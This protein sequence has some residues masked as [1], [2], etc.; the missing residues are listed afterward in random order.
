M[1]TIFSAALGVT[2]AAVI[3]LVPFSAQA[4]G[5]YATGSTGIDNSYPSCHDKKIPVAGKAFGIIGVNGGSNYTQNPCAKALASMFSSTQTVSLYVNT[6]LY[7]GGNYFAQAMRDGNCGSN[8]SCGAYW[9]GYNAGA[10]AYNY[11]KSQGLGVTPT[12]WWLDVEETNTWNADLALNTQ[13]IR[14]EYAAL[15]ERI[16]AGSTIGIYAVT[17][18]WNLIVGSNWNR[19][20]DRYPVWAADGLSSASKVQSYCTG[21]SITGGPIEIVQYVVSKQ[22]YDQGC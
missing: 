18:Q 10:Y 21:Y 12:R 7:T 6:G 20:V 3:A 13:S 16:S 22:D 4:S 11:A 19:D 2:I 17:S 15:S 1:R 14:G 5:L 9:H 8:L